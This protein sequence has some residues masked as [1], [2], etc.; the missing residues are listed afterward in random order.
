MAT[1][2]ARKL[3]V[4]GLPESITEEVLR[5]IFEATGGKVVE[6]S[7]PRE[8]ATGKVRGFGFVT[9]STS[10]E[11]NRARDELDGSL[12]AGRSISVRPFSSEPPKRGERTEMRSDSPMGPGGGG[13]GGGGPGGASEDRTLYVG[14]L[15]YDT[16]QQ[17]LTQ[18]LTELGVGPVARIHLPTGPDGRMR[19]FG[20]VT[21]GTAEAAQAAL[22]LLNNADIRGRRLMINIAHPRGDRPSMGPGGDRSR[23]P[24]P[25]GGPRYPTE[26]PMSFEGG[27]GPREGGRTAP[28]PEGDSWDSR[29]KKKK[30]KGAT[31]GRERP[32][33]ERKRGGG[34]SWRSLADSDDED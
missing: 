11:A 26:P 14:N 32:G 19:G 4:A 24:P 15:P 10:E 22:G 31:P 9:F 18:F 6:V 29:P 5:Q 27:G 1:E 2:D 25:M 30:V 13:G 23:P 3:F 8:R 17:E 33:D 7:L 21:L 16:S 12:Q 34:S 28:P 20:F